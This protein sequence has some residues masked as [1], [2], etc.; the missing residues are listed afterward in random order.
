MV[1]FVMIPCDEIDMF[2]T[3]WHG[4]CLQDY[5]VLLVPTYQTTWHVTHIPVCV[6][7]AGSLYWTMQCHW[8]PSTGLCIA[9]GSRIVPD[10]T[11]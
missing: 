4:A 8:Y 9:T 10:F 2:R 6:S 5:V 11:L 7:V 1:I 3:V